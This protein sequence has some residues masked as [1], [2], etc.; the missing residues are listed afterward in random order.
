VERVVGNAGQV[1]DH[2]HISALEHFG[3]FL[4]LLCSPTALLVQ[5]ASRSS[6][7]HFAL[8]LSCTTPI[9]LSCYL[10]L[11]NHWTLIFNYFFLQA[12]KL[13][14]TSNHLGDDARVRH[15]FP[16]LTAPSWSYPASIGTHDSHVTHQNLD[17]ACSCLSQWDLYMAPLLLWR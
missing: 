9:L 15:P 10:G 1:L 4:S 2:V 12:P 14:C 16:P 7:E 3:L 13:P 8:I 6:C 5:S 17:P 11:Q